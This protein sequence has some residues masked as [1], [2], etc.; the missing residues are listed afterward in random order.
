MVVIHRFAEVAN[1]P[2]LQGAPPDSLVRVCGDE[3]RRNGV[4]HIDE[5]SVEFDSGHSRHLDVGDQARG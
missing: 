5:M 2:V 3:D 4:A 1:D